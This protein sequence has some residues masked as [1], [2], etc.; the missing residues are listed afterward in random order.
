MGFALRWEVAASQGKCALSFGV[1]T[2]LLHGR[3]AT[4]SCCNWLRQTRLNRARPQSV[5]LVAN[6]G[7]WR[8]KDR[9]VTAP[10]P[11]ECQKGTMG[12]VASV[13]DTVWKVVRNAR[14]G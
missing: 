4:A 10:L 9:R 3:S 6:I 11:R 5:D 14:N 8:L 13:S 7:V 1:A 2:L 12:S